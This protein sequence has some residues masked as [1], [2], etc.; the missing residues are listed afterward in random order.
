EGR[1]FEYDMNI[2]MG[3]V[4]K[5]TKMAFACYF[6]LAFEEAKIEP[7]KKYNQKKNNMKGAVALFFSIQMQEENNKKKTKAQRLAANRS[8]VYELVKKIIQLWYRPQNKNLYEQLQIMSRRWDD[9]LVHAHQITEVN[10][11][12]KDL[13]VLVHGQGAMIGM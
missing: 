12:F 2:Q 5:T 7:Q 1:I 9:C 11:I 13:A 10:E 4:V 8:F 3:I 6:Y